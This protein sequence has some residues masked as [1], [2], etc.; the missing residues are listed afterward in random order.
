MELPRDAAHRRGGCG[1]GDLQHLRP[2]ARGRT[3]PRSARNLASPSSRG[4][5]STRARWPGRFAPTR[6]SPRA[7]LPSHLLRR[8]EP[9]ATVQRVE[10]A[11]RAAGG[12]GAARSGLALCDLGSGGAHR[13]PR[14]AAS[15]ARA[16]ERRGSGAGC[17]RRWYARCCA[18]IAGI[19]C[20][21]RGACSRSMRSRSARRCH[22]RNGF[23]RR[24][25]PG[26]ARSR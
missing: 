7:R 14:H 10:A 2:G 1:A 18:R 16:R 13:H 19:A 21:R 8:R 23:S 22:I 26:R 4:C 25:M 17:F 20:P 12:A 9:A 11:R 6:R 3:L 5:R 15:C 24:Q